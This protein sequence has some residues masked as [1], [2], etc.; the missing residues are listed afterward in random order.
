MSDNA[1]SN[2]NQ[3]QYDIMAKYNK[4]Q[5]KLWWKKYDETINNDWW[6]HIE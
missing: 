5:L 4:K 3:I 2:D 1:S 6:C